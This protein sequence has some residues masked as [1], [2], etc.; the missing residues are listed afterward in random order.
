MAW[1][2]ATAFPSSVTDVSAAATPPL[3]VYGLA[4]AKTVMGKVTV[5]VTVPI[6]RASSQHQSVDTNSFDLYDC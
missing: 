1:R 3:V 2:L 5:T 6:V 4:V